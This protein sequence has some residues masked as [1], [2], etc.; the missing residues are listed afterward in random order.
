MGSNVSLHMIDE[1]SDI[2]NYLSCQTMRRIHIHSV[3][4]SFNH[5]CIHSSTTH[6]H[7]HAFNNQ[8]PIAHTPTHTHC[9][10]LVHTLQ[11]TLNVFVLTKNKRITTNT[12]QTSQKRHCTVSSQKTHTIWFHVLYPKDKQNWFAPWWTETHS[13]NFAWKPN[14]PNGLHAPSCIWWFC[15]FTNTSTFLI[16]KS[17]PRAAICSTMRRIFSTW[18][19]VSF[20]SSSAHCSIESSL[21]IEYASALV[22]L[23]PPL[24]TVLNFDCHKNT[25]ATN[26]VTKKSLSLTWHTEWRVIHI[27]MNIAIHENG[28]ACHHPMHAK[29]KENCNNKQR[30]QHVT[31]ANDAHIPQPAKIAIHA[32]KSHVSQNVNGAPRDPRSWP[33]PTHAR[34]PETRNKQKSQ[35]VA[36]AAN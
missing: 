30:S 19:Y 13:N 8:L 28:I 9:L 6:S 16:S 7:A 11:S 10:T 23:S 2:K 34:S 25:A 22:N 15:F 1:K 12:A 14:Q 35:H 24:W 29:N 33:H 3:M 4:Q 18:M 21:K 17:F 26:C 20:G 5:T 31:D 32:T 27:S 36:N